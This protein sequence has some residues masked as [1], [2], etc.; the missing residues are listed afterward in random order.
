MSWL[1][2]QR[3]SI[4]QMYQCGNVQMYNAIGLCFFKIDFEDTIEVGT[5][6]VVEY[7]GPL[8]TAYRVVF[9]LIPVQV[10]FHSAICMQM[11]A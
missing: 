2:A 10:A 9:C 7:K 6:R 3:P 4:L 1:S 8:A 11:F 5:F